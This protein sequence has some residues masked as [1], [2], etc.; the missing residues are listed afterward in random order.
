MN[1]QKSLPR[2]IGMGFC[3][4]ATVLIV[5]V[6]LNTSPS[7]AAGAVK[8]M[9]LGDSIT[10]GYNIPGGYR[11]DLWTHL[12]NRGWDVDFVGSMSN[13]PPSLPDKNHEGHSGWMISQIALQ[14][15]GWLSTYQPE[16][17][18]LLIGTNDVLQNYDLPNAPD[19]LSSLIDQITAGAPDAEVFVASIT[20]L[21]GTTANQ[22]VIAYNAAIPGIVAEKVALGK[23]VSFVDMYSALTVADLADG[24]HPNAAGYDKMAQVWNDAIPEPATL[25]LLGFG[26]IG[27]LLKRRRKY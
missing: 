27:V 9:P 23:S 24:I 1:R 13:G 22:K 6:A 18:L 15:D 2:Y 21:S 26:G 14:I 17:V 4:C 8:I 19:R 11:I 12:Q 10:D 5:L 25:S 3:L 20:P 7:T 16:Y